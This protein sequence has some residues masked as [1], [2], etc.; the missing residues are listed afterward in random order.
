MNVLDSAIQR[1]YLKYITN[2]FFYD[3]FYLFYTYIH[4]LKESVTHSDIPFGIFLSV[5]K[6]MESKNNLIK[7]QSLLAILSMALL[8]LDSCLIQSFDIDY[9]STYL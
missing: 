7:F 3:V 9:I 1:L 4:S 5:R 6:G 8:W 2:G